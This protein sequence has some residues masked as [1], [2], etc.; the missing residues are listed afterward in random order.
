MCSLIVIQSCKDDEVSYKGDGVNEHHEI[1]IVGAGISGLTCGYYLGNKDFLILEKEDKVGGRVISGMHDNFVYA[2]GAEYLGEPDSYLAKMIKGLGL[3]IKEIPSPMDA[4]YDGKQFYYGTD[5]IARYLIHGSDVATYNKFVNL[6]LQADKLYDEVPD[7]T[8]TAKVRDL[9]HTTA[10]NWLLGNA[11]PKIYI[12]KYNVASRGLFGA[13]LQEISA[14]SFIPEAAFDYDEDDLIQG[15][16]KF[17]EENEYKNAM[18]ERS[19]SYTFV[20]GLTELTNALGNRFSDKIRLKSEVTA[21]TK[22][23]DHYVI[24]YRTDGGE[25]RMLTTNKVVAAVPSPIVLNIAPTLLPEK[26]KD[27]LNQIEYSSYATVALFSKVPIFNKAFDLAVPD[28]YF[29][30][31]IYDATWVR[32]HFESIEPKE[33]IISV[34]IAPLSYTDHSLDQMRDDDILNRVYGDLD[35][36][37]PNASSL[38]TGYD[39]QHF[40]YAYPVMTLG[41]YERL[42]ELMKLNKGSFVLAGDYT[43]YP[44]FESAVESGYMAAEEVK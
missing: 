34:Y 2:K 35:K 24:N 44:T 30:T 16:G 39:I 42:V 28:G 21:I 7:L 15:S 11:I 1:V 26:V 31:D 17:D 37:F 14:Y 23:D 12:D 29:F 33:H 36:I 32:R 22:E 25:I 41:A 20:N 8:Y 3:A 43:I 5:G 6:L 13:S 38:V 18:D 10:E 27:I 40:K 9:D 19:E 4:F